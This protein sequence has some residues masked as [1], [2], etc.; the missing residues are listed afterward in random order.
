M[1]STQNRLQ[2]MEALLAEVKAS[3]EDLGAAFVVCQNEDRHEITE[4]K[5][6]LSIF[7]NKI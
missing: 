6:M 3:H 5:K 2:K 4:I 7:G 1:Q